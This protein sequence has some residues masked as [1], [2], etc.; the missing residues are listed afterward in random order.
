MPLYMLNPV[1]SMN[2]RVFERLW[3]VGG[4]AWAEIKFFISQVQIQDFDCKS[5]EGEIVL[6]VLCKSQEDPVCNMIL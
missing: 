3:G 4:W 5:K 6:I 2:P 1:P